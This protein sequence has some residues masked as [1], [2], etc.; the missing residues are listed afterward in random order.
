MELSLPV[1]HTLTIASRDPDSGM[2]VAISPADQ[3]GQGDGTTQF[4][5]VYS[6]GTEV[7]LCACLFE[8]DRRFKQWLA[9]GEPISTEPTVTVK[10]D[11]ERTLRAV[12]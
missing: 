3:N 11:Y 12:Y 7:K 6:K 4:T 1:L 10:M 2:T 5:R 9:N 8:G